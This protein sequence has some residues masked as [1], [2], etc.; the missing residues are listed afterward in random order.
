MCLLEL[1][2]M[3]KTTS[4]RELGAAFEEEWKYAASVFDRACAYFYILIIIALL[5]ATLFT[6]FWKDT[7]AHY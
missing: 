2:T 7:S 5:L 4:D 3:N 1:V 6:R